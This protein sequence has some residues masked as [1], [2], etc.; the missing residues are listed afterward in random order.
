MGTQYNEVS[1]LPNAAYRDYI[2]TYADIWDHY[3]IY[4]SGQYEYTGYVWDDWGNSTLITIE[5]ENETGYNSRW[6]TSIAFD[7]QHSYTIVEPMYAYS[8]E[9]GDG[10][11]YMPQNFQATS[12]IAQLILTVT[13][14][15]VL[16]FRRIFLWLRR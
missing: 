15:I 13:V 8:T 12:A 9:R 5:R 6:R 16:V 3:V 4:Q 10:Q 14:A 1:G 7:V 11:Y 2:L